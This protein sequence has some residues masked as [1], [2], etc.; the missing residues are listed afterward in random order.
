MEEIAEID[1]LLD[2]QFV[3]NAIA[4]AQQY[5]TLEE[6]ISVLRWCYECARTSPHATYS[7]PLLV[8]AINRLEEAK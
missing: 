7:M 8:A 3:Q 2:D 4:F 1:L 5:D 6:R